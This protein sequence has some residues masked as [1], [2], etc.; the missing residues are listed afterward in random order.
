MRL[1][2]HTEAEAGERQVSLSER[3]GDVERGDSSLGRAGIGSRPMR[4]FGTQGCTKTL[5]NRMRDR[6]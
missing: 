2:R 6:C 5:G 3:E 1:F 4:A